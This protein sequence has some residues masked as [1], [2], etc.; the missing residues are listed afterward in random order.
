V[1]RKTFGAVFGREPTDDELDQIYVQ[2][3]LNLSAD[4]VVSEGYRMLPGADQCLADL[5]KAG[6]LLGLVS[7]AMEVLQ[8]PSSFLPISTASSYLARTDR[9]HPI[10]P[11]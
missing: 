9:T 5:G 7:G 6:V 3:L 11:S 10:A 8:A 1:A 2:Y 4:I